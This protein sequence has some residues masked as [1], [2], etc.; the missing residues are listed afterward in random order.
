M[1]ANKEIMARNIKYYMDLHQ[2]SRNEL[3]NAISV[4]YTTLRDWLK[5]KTYPRI[6]KIE[7]MA[8]YFGISK[9][10][11]VEDKLPTDEEASADLIYKIMN[12]SSLI[13]AI[14]KYY[15]LSEDRQELVKRIIENL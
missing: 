6:D 2:V 7:L 10:Y 4:P 11:L 1:I 14:Q 9:A 5:A 12:D 8:N 3:A 15:E 13:S